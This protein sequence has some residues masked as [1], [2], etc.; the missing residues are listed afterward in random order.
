MIHCPEY[1][2]KEVEKR[3]SNGGFGWAELPTPHD[4]LTRTLYNLYRATAKGAEEEN[5]ITICYTCSN[6][7][8]NS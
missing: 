2:C 6:G 5:S 8:I 7:L 1:T 4:R 3:G